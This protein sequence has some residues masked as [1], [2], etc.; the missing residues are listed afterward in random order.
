MQVKQEQLNPCEVELEVE[1]E[2]EK[3][4]SAIDST[5]EDVA[6]TITVPGFRKGKAPRAIL[7]SYLD[8]E[9]IKERAARSL[10]RDAYSEALTESKLEP[11]APADVDLVKF[12]IG[13]PMIFKAKVPLAPQVELGEYVGVKVE[14]SLREIVDEDVEKQIDS[15]RERAAELVPVTD[16]PVQNG[17]VV[18][19]KLS[20]A[21]EEQPPLRITV[22]ENLPEFDQGLVGMSVGEEKAIDVTYPEDYAAEE[23]RGESKH[24]DVNVVGIDVKQMPELTDEWIKSALGGEEEA[25]GSEPDADRIDT[26]EKLRARIRASMDRAAVQEADQG[27]RD[28]VVEKVIGNATICFPEFMVDETV[29]HRIAELAERLKER[30]L[31]VEDYLKHTNQ[32]IEDLRNS[33]D[34]DARNYLKLL[35]VFREIVDKEKIEVKDEDY[36]AEIHGVAQER[37]TTPEAVRAYIEKAGSEESVRNRILREK[38]VDFLVHASN[39]KN[40][41]PKVSAE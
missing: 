1:V 29:D 31:S 5:Y 15:I 40:V 28:K 9:E 21:D 19:V 18:S 30:K 16:R 39:I 4:T 12:E 22:G 37:G 6:R 14:R 36:D 32:T 41:G 11:F 8:K 35:L 17:D 7:E 38:V 34:E 3:V 20:G 24:W 23:L 25:E 26:V 33:Y 2:V 13:E 27:V 10:L